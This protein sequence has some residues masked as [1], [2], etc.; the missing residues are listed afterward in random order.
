[1]K[2]QMQEEGK[3]QQKEDDEIA[4]RKRKRE[5]EKEWEATRDQRI[6]SWRDFQKKDG[7][8]KKG[9]K[10]KVKVLG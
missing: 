9:K 1:M 2:V 6:G 7:G 8:D 4:E 3:A 10:K 5:H